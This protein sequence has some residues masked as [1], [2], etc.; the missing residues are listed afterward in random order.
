M[1]QNKNIYCRV[2][3]NLM[4][5][6]LISLSKMKFKFNIIKNNNK[7]KGSNSINNKKLIKLLNSNH[8]K[9]LFNSLLANHYLKHIKSMESFKGINLDSISFHQFII[10]PSNK[11]IGI[12]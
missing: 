2:N 7:K 5:Y 4:I 1:K 12:F 3:K 6:N 10:Y 8:S 11:L 9:N